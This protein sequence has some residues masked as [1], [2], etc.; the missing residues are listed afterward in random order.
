M[1]EKDILTL[2]LLIS[3]I[4]LIQL[5]LVIF[6]LLDLLKRPQVRGP[7]WAWA[8]GLIV[9]AFGIPTGIIIAAIYLVW[10]RHVEGADDTD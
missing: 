3:P 6:A 2:V 1:T 5:G 8:A 4:F 7:K 10:G 9:T